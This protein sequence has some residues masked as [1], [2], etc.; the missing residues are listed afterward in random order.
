MYDDATER[1]YYVSDY[2]NTTGKTF[3]DDTAV[4]VYY[5]NVK[6]GVSDSYA[7][8]AYDIV[9]RGNWYGPVTAKDQLPNTSQWKITLKNSERAIINQN[10]EN[11]TGGGTLP[12]NF[13]YANYAA[14]LLTYQE[15]NALCNTSSLTNSCKYLFEN[16]NYAKSQNSLTAWWL[17]NAYFYN[18]A[19]AYIINSVSKSIATRYVTNT[20]AYVGVRPAIEV[21]KTN[22][23]Y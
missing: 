7:P 9:N 6:S 13:S 10:G 8:F 4:F 23:S 22:I 3:E 14:R 21:Q 1:F 12:A 5:N 19:D 18:N 2:Y 15:I 17:E 11:T 16:T 20:S